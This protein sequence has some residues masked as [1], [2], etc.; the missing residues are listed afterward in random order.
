MSRLEQNGEPLQTQGEIEA[1]VCAELARFEQEHLGRGPKSVDASL[2]GDLL[3]VRMQGVLTAAEQHLVA[4]QPTDRGRDLVKQMRTQLIETA[5]PL[6]SGMIEK[7]TGVAVR[8][9]HHDISTV[10]GE[11]LI[12]F[13]LMHEPRCRE[14]KRR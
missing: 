1:A 7:I 13:A 6:L 9:L 11:E 2:Q 3:V 5:S 8:S 14:R 12:T 4:A 10:T